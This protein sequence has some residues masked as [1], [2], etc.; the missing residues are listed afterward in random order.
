MKVNV[1]DFNCLTDF[2]LY[3]FDEMTTTLLGSS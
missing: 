1:T 3:F 2:Y